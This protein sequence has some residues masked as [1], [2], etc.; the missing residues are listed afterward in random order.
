[1]PALIA[2]LIFFAL[3][4][5]AAHMRGEYT[6]CLMALLNFIGTIVAIVIIVGLLYGIMIVSGGNDLLGFI[7]L[8]GIV[9]LCYWLGNKLNKS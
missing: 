5:Y 3:S 8:F 6:G 7:L 4:A 9:V 1:M 2:F